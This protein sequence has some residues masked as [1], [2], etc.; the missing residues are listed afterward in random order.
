MSRG[1][2]I[3]IEGGD[4]S[5]KTTILNG[6]KAILDKEGVDY[7][8]T[9]E[10]GGVPISEDIRDIILDNKNTEMDDR[11]EALLFAA[12]RRQHLV[13]KILPA[14][15]EGKL[16]IVDRFIDSSIAYQGYAREIGVDEVRMVNEFA[17]ADNYPDKTIYIDIDPLLALQRVK[18][19]G[20]EENRLD[21]EKLEFHKL[22]REGYFKLCDIEDRMVLIDGSKDID[23]L[24][25]DVYEQIKEVI[26]EF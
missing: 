23:S 15:N 21:L 13:E 5:G 9:R 4:G 1:K 25:N 22:V 17:I 3:S 8:I 6:I 24:I 18:K 20:R 10:P 14:L 12:A 16:V 26:N 2:F 7:I 19:N 11:T